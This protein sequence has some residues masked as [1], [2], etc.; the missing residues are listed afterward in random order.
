ML[1]LVSMKEIGIM[2]SQM[3][4]EEQFKIMEMSMMDYLKMVN[5]MVMDD[6]TSPMETI[7]KVITIITKEMVLE[8]SSG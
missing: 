4:K 6:I 7:M 1:I 8:H 2:I 5:I 3:E